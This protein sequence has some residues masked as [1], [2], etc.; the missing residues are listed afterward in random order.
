MLLL[1]TAC[2]YTFR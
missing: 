1:T 2:V